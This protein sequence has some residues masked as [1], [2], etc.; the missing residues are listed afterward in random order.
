MSRYGHFMTRKKPGI[1]AQG[2]SVRH[3]FPLMRRTIPVLD[4]T[5]KMYQPADD[6]ADLL[7]PFV[8]AKRRD[9]TDAEIRRR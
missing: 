1:E 3:H 2:Y 4:A 9:T 5:A 6:G 8:R 7:I